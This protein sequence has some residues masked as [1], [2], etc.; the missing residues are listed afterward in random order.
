MKENRALQS[1]Q[2]ILAAFFR[3]KRRLPSY[4]EMI[5]LLGV[6]SKSVVH[7]WINKLIAAGIPDKGEK[8]RLT[9]RNRYFAVPL[10]GSVQAGFPSPEEEALCDVMSRGEY[11]FP[12]RERA[13]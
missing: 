7:F 10:V 2:K 4:A 11:L 3:E 1:V 6:R 9:M 5:P 13:Y 12:R 8:G